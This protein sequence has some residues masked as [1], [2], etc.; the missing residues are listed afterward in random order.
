[1]GTEIF[2]ELGFLLEASDDELGLPSTGAAS[3][4]EEEA[5]RVG[6][7]EP[8]LDGQ[9]WGLEGGGAP[10]LLG[11]RQHGLGSGFRVSV[12]GHGDD[13]PCCRCFGSDRTPGVAPHGAFRSRTVSTTVA[14]WFVPIARG[15]MNKVCRFG[16]L[17][18]A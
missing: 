4:S 15:T 2:P 11:R 8:A 7:P 16:P 17:G 13:G 5:G 10:F 1:L 3:S 18:S 9:I 6:A 12:V 14:K